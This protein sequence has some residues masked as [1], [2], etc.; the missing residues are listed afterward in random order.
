[1]VDDP[2]CPTRSDWVWSVLAS[3]WI[4]TYSAARVRGVGRVSGRSREGARKVHGLCVDLPLP[5]RP[6]SFFPPAGSFR[7]AACGVRCWQ[8]FLSQVYLAAR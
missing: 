5:A 7:F 8:L 2:I 3:A 1:M 4:A 6:R